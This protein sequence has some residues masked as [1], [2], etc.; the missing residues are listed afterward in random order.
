LC[1]PTTPIP[2]KLISPN[3]RIQHLVKA[4]ST[5]HANQPQ[6]EGGDHK[7]QKQKQLQ[8]ETAE[9]ASQRK[10]HR[11]T[12]NRHTVARKNFK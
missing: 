11:V 6:K 5:Y 7:S 9:A 1:P 12:K 2:L 3:T 8:T 4:N 10:K